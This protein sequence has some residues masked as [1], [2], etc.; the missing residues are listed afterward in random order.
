M[1]FARRISMDTYKMA[2][3]VFCLAGLAAAQ[4]L[5]PGCSGQ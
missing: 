3:G 2:E 5:S 4:P 1:D